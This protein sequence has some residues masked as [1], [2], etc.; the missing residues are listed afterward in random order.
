MYFLSFSVDSAHMSK[1]FATAIY[2]LRKIKRSLKHQ[3]V[4]QIGF[5][6]RNLMF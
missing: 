6:I 2:V 1:L 4:L 5:A 3:N